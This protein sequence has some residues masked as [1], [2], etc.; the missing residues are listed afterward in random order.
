M[1]VWSEI[2]KVAVNHLDLS[3]IPDDARSYV[4]AALGEAIAA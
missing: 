4:R 3:L 2:N 1:S